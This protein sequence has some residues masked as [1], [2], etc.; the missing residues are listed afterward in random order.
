VKHLTL[1]WRLTLFYA[2]LSSAI[3]LV[4]GSV[5][6]FS[7]RASLREMLDNSLHDAASLAASQLT[8]D[9]GQPKFSETDAESLQRE[10]QGETTL[11][12]FNAK[13]HQTDRLGRARV[14]APLKAGFTSTQGFRAY[15]IQTEKGDWVQAL[16]S[17]A[18]TLE[19]LSRAQ[20][21][22]LFTVPLMLLAGLGA[23][24]LIADRALRPVDQVSRLASSIAASGRYQDR[25]PESAGSDEMA[26]LTSTVN[27]MLGKLEATIERERAFALAAAHE[28]RT[29]LAL[30]R[31]QASL[32]LR[33]E[34]T[35]DEYR[36]VIESVDQTS[37]EMT[38]LVESLLALARTNQ[39]LQKQAVNLEDIALEVVES[40][41]DTARVRSIRLI[42]E[43]MSAP[44]HGDPAALR[45]LITNLIGNSI[46]YG[47]EGGHVWLRTSGH[48]DHVMLEVCD[49]GPGIEAAD[50]ERLTQPFQRGLG[51][52]AVSG[53]GLGLALALAV[54]EQHGGTLELSRAAE[55]GLRAVVLLDG[56]GMGAG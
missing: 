18:D 22:L 36:Q 15:T 38:G 46:K 14:T 30:L 34:R 55:G 13:Q 19:T 12:V 29:P 32:S 52:Q 50:L 1:R 27:S 39:A 44:T 9:E 7:L 40:L 42:L 17:E 11:V 20:R 16:R 26:R 4:T 24:Y 10:V 2:L 21:L 48:A 3:L 33:R 25:V 53:T 47:H 8:G 37:L 6:F 41:S 56:D 35:S 54:A 28:L 31:G 23:G 43:T 5:F 51:L 45:L 49:D